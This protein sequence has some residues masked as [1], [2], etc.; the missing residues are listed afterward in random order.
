MLKRKTDLD[1]QLFI[2]GDQDLY[3]SS[4]RPLANI[5]GETLTCS[6]ELWGWCLI[7][8]LWWIDDVMLL[9]FLLLYGQFF[10][11]V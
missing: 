5:A 10:D 1:N 2:L 3:S 6:P 11:V 4:V 9:V 7:P 8:Q